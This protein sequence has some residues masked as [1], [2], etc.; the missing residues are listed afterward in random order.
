MIL[1]IL[2]FSLSFALTIFSTAHGLGFWLVLMVIHGFLV[3][4]FGD[5]AVH[6][7]MYCGILICLVILIRG[8]WKGLHTWIV[9]LFVSLAIGMLVAAIF[10]LNFN[11]SL[12]GSFLYLKNFAL[13]LV[14]AGC[15]RSSQEIRILILYCL[16]AL[17]FG[18]LLACYQ[19]ITGSYSVASIYQ[20][21]AG[22]LRADPNDTAM[23]LLAGVPIAYYWFNRRPEISLKILSLASLGLI[24]IGL[25]LTGSRG[26]FLATSFVLA[27]LYLRKP[28]LPKTA[29]GVVMVLVAVAFAPTTF[30][31]RITSL[32]TG[33]EKYGSSSIEKRG[34]LLLTGV[35][36]FLDNV[37]VGVG[38]GN[39]AAGYMNHIS[40]ST[41][42]GG[43]KNAISNSQNVRGAA[44]N[45][46]LEFFVENGIL[47]GIIFI[48][49]LWKAIMG[50]LA[51]KEELPFKG[52]RH[53]SMGFMLAVSLSGMLF[54]GLFLSQGKN[55]VLWFMIG[56]GYAAHHIQ[57]KNISKKTVSLHGK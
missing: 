44:H 13:V 11:V 27:V 40:E 33:V 57:A 10:G 16:G 55:P 48:T 50:L 24:L 30:K 8:Q 2:L 46:Y 17:T 15:V 53:Y 1:L 32:F 54:A 31:E 20:Q 9:G 45:L 18:A 34:K 42:G 3:D 47:T 36:V 6:I 4:R 38:V 39:F 41:V 43:S 7:P 28:T 5:I 25:V 52:M 35:E 23:L 29:M 49:V 21:R 26:G 14:I 19:K 37:I 12:T 22:G 51:L 56:L